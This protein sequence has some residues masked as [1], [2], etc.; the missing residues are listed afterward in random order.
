M[1]TRTIVANGQS[2]FTRTVGDPSKPLVLFL[3]GF[4]E[5]GG[6]WDHILPRFA[7]NY[8]AAAP[9]QRGYGRSSKPSGVDNYKI[10][11]LV[12]DMLALA[13][14][15]APGKPINVVAHDWGASVGYGMAMF[16]PRRISK[17]VVLNGVHPLPFQRAL[18]HDPEQRA[19]SQYIRFLRRDDSATLLSA[20][21]FARVFAMLSGDFGGGRW[22]T[23]AK[24]AGY[25]DAWSQPGAME[26]MV[27][28]YKATP[29][30]VPGADETVT[31][32]P[33]AHINPELMRVRI[34]HLLLWGLEDKAL[35]PSCR[36]GLEHQCGSLE[37]IDVPN[38]DHWIA[39]QQPDL[40][41]EHIRR[42]FAA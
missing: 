3:H 32:D 23:A 15:L 21:N 13:E 10:Q 31:A 27:S 4:P 41:V 29:L 18:I 20:D 2:F 38:A 16:A 34:P 22:L 5:Y 8:M 36:A 17:L 33:L 28:W 42:F 24:K 37:V 25:L 40:V 1:Q 9:D 14:Q 35:R 6:A 19:A 7:D 30:V 11:H 26:A 39:H 12:A